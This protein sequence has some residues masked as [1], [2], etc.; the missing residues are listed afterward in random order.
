M[1]RSLVTVLAVAGLGST[2]SGCQELVLRRDEGAIRHSFLLEKPLGT[3][4]KE[5]ERWIK[6]R[7]WTDIKKT[8]SAE[9]T[10][11]TARCGSYISSSTAGF[12]INVVGNW[13]FNH[14]GELSEVWVEKIFEH[15]P[16]TAT[17]TR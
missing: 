16:A 7:S 1:N 2:L 15:T 6:S 11:L 13:K 3:P 14:R 12:P 17:P 9:T 5:I 10:L 4:M 8:A